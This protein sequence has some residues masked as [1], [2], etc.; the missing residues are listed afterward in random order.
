MPIKA[1]IVVT[2]FDRKASLIRMLGALN[3]QS[4][5]NKLFEVILV[6]DSAEKRIADEVVESVNTGYDLSVKRTCLP[7]AINGVSV[8][9][10]IGIK[11]ARGNIIISV[12]DDC[13]PNQYFVEEHLSFHQT[14]TSHIVLGHRTERAE[15]LKERRPV[16]VTE[17]KAMGELRASNAGTLNFLNFMTG[18]VSFS[19]R[20]AIRAGLFDERFARSGEHGWEDIEFGY[21]LWRLGYRTVFAPDA[22]VYRPPTE[23]A[24]ERE[25]TATNAV[26]KGRLRLRLLQPRLEVVV[27]FLR[28]VLQDRKDMVPDVAKNVLAEDPLNCGVL[29]TLGEFYFHNGRYDK[30]LECFLNAEEKN[31]DLHQVKERIAETQHRIEEKEQTAS[32]PAMVETV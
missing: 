10:N 14:G 28:A 12:D 22:V 23:E 16:F 18:N 27:E 1:T 20:S 8:G 7:Y 21:R 11:A 4:T 13:I 9:R 29:I 31:D 6:D 32:E 15:K 24:K 25:R 26:K 3:H 17:A 30:A 19:K 5:S 2:A